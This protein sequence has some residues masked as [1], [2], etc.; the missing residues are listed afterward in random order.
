M[1]V[2]INVE[3]AKVT[4]GIFCHE[5]IHKQLRDAAANAGQD[6]ITLNAGG[7]VAREVFARAKEIVYCEGAFSNYFQVDASFKM[8]RQGG[9]LGVDG[10][11][12]NASD[13]LWQADRE[14]RCTAEKSRVFLKSVYGEFPAQTSWK[15]AQDVASHMH[16]VKRQ[17]DGTFV[18]DC[19]AFWHSVECSHVMAA[20]HLT[21]DVNV[22]DELMTITN[23]KRV[24]RPSKA[25]ALPISL[26]THDIV[27][28][29][30]AS[31]MKA[32]SYIGTKIARRLNHV[33]HPHSM[34]VYYG[35]V[36]G[37]R[38]KPGRNGETVWTVVYPAQYRDEADEFEGGADDEELNLTAMK[39]GKRLYDEQLRLQKKTPIST[40]QAMSSPPAVVTTPLQVTALLTGPRICCK[41]QKKRGFG[42]CLAK[43]QTALPT[44]KC[45]PNKIYWGCNKP[46]K[47]EVCRV[48]KLITS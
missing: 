28:V 13:H 42:F 9:L 18:C 14:Y 19:K 30:N 12:I 22:D 39:E 24:G 43:Q 32:S 16:F 36:S 6:V 44:A 38:T 34:R 37:S 1:F 8:N 40:P 31:E 25:E 17:Q 33:N 20:L 48:C 45:H 46:K 41:C 21:G 3:N 10:F 23:G 15:A 7:T 27:A 5:G 29:T 2:A 4:L 47:A 35:R 26:S 11:V